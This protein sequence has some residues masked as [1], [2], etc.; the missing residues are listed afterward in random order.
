MLAAT[1]AGIFVIPLLYVV[2]QSMSEWRPGAR[3]NQ[4]PPA[5][6]PR[7]APEAV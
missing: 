5:V 1:L 4:P 7:H 6:P 3:K 2:F